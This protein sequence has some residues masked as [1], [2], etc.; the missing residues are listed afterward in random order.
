[1]KQLA[2]FLILSLLAFNFSYSQ[3]VGIN[4]TG[5]DPDPSAGLDVNFSDRGLLIPRLTTAQRDAIVSPAE[6]L[7]VFNTTTKCFEYY[8]YENWQ[9]LHCA[10]CP[11]TVPPTPLAHTATVS[12]ITWNWTSVPE[13]LGYRV[14]TTNNYNTASNIGLNTSYVLS[15]LTCETPY[16]LF[17]WSYNNCGHSE[18]IGLNHST[19][20]CPFECGVSTVT[21]TYKGSSVT[22]G[23]VSSAGRCWLDRN[24]GAPN[25][26]NTS[27]DINAY[28]DMFQWGRLDDGHQNR[29][30][31]T[32]ST[33]SSS[34]VPGHPNF[35]TP[36]SSPYD[37]RSPQNP[38]L[39]Q[40]VSGPN[41]PCPAGWRIPTDTEWNTERLSWSS[42]TASGA[43]SSPLKL[44][45]AG[46][47][48]WDGGI[49]LAGDYGSYWSSTVPTQDV[50]YIQF[51]DAGGL[52]R[53]DGVRAFGHSVRCIRN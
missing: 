50:N 12:S 34:D 19:S 53:T 36:S 23:T 42:N 31:S 30:S 22:M 35:I 15:D 40:G 3:G 52:I 4:P 51:W 25:V 13:A 43:F 41:N 39:W 48:S 9:I 11:G 18:S 49:F 5:A 14:S 1:M 10:S 2:A 47:R 21:F 7:Q 33:L 45:K 16:T 46:I 8:A 24:L 38:A 32:T 44:T 17:V 27:T 6:G 28:G 29:T 26:A 37:W 20:D